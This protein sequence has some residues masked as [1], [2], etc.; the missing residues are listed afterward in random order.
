MIFAATSCCV[1]QEERMANKN[2]KNGEGDMEDSELKICRE[3]LVHP[4]V[5]GDEF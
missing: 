4:R 5:S 2:S 1:A 3:K